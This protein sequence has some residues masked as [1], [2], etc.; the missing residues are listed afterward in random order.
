LLV[1][2]LEQPERAGIFKGDKRAAGWYAPANTVPVTDISALRKTL[3]LGPKTKLADT[4]TSAIEISA[5]AEQQLRA[6]FDEH[7]EPVLSTSPSEAPLVA[8]ITELLEIWRRTRATEVADLIDRATR[9]LPRFDRPLLLEQ[10]DRDER[11]LQAW[12]TERDEAMPQ[13]LRHVRYW[14]LPITEEAPDDPRI[15]RMLAR[16]VLEGGTFW[17]PVIERS[18]DATAWQAVAGVF[19]ELDGVRQPGIRDAFRFAL[20]RLP[21]VTLDATDRACVQAIDALLVP[22][23]TEQALV[24]AIAEHPD[25]DDPFLIY[26]DWL[27]ERGHP[28]GEYIALACQK[29]HN[30][31]SPA[32]ARRLATLERVPYL[33]G[34][35]DEVATTWQ[36]ARPRGIDRTLEVYGSPTSLTWLEVARHPLV[37]ALESIRFVFEPNVQRVPGLVAVARAAPRLRQINDVSGEVASRLVEELGTTW[38]RKGDDVVRVDPR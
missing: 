23:L 30:G 6:L 21:P 17:A 18:R 20:T 14:R 27:L 31:L 36:R 24:D 22:D 3:R 9:M 15:A 35:L 29:R 26:S 2:A 33:F 7:D 4:L 1:A 8:R 13:L 37:R 38:Q 5:A 11:W 34:P 32:L 16:R 19:A 25:D 28:R 10:S 12:R